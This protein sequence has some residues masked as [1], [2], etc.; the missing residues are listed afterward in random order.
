MALDEATKDRYRQAG[1]AVMA[2]LLPELRREAARAMKAVKEF[3]DAKAS[4]ENSD[5]ELAETMNVL[6]ARLS[7]RIPD[8]DDEPI[9]STWWF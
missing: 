5:I 6:I 2:A 1:P 3:E 8:D 7:S 4:F 9:Y